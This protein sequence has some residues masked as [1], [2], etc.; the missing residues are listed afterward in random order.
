M[1]AYL[2]LKAYLPAARPGAFCSAGLRLKPVVHAAGRA[3]VGAGQTKWQGARGEE[4]KEDR[5]VATFPSLPPTCLL[6]LVKVT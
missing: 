6:W 5:N 2:L 3:D 1:G 4:R